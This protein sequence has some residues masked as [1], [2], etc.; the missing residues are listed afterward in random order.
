MLVYLKTTFGHRDDSSDCFQRKALPILT[1][2]DCLFKNN[3]WPA[4]RQLRLFSTEGAILMNSAC[5]FQNHLRLPGFQIKNTLLTNGARCLPISQTTFGC[6]R[7][8]RRSKSE[9][10]ALA[11]THSPPLG[12]YAAYY[13][14]ASRRCLPLRCLVFLGARDLHDSSVSYGVKWLLL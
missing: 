14:S 8:G 11:V 9:H 13:F 2:S 4:G 3:L 1:N 10:P 6:A 12:W 5:L 7:V